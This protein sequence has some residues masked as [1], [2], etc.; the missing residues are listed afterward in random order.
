M[1]FLQ[2]PQP[3]S[4]FQLLDAETADDNICVLSRMGEQSGAEAALAIPAQ[5]G[6]M[7]EAEALSLQDFLDA[8]G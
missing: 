8:L 5:Y 6:E 4:F 2:P 1:L 7:L 3:R